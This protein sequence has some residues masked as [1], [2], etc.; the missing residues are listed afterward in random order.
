MTAEHEQRLRALAEQRDVWAWALVD[1][2]DGPASVQTDVSPLV[3]ALLADLARLR[4]LVEISEQ[5][6]RILRRDQII[7]ELEADLAST[8][9]ELEAMATSARELEDAAERED[10]LL[11][12][13]AKARAERDQAH[14]ALR[15]IDRAGCT[16]GNPS[17]A[18]VLMLS[19]AK[20]A[21]L[22]V[23]AAEEY[24]PPTP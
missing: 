17:E 19:Y 14:E 1:T 7:R 11:A 2:P 13:L 8:R 21:L 6:Q 24:R 3:L 22:R 20:S 16:I 9:A 5:A 18:A 12:D 23:A 10:R 4:N 15:R